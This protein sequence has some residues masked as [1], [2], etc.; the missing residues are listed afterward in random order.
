MYLDPNY[1]VQ[2]DLVILDDPTTKV[3]SVAEIK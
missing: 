2:G 1:N 3:V